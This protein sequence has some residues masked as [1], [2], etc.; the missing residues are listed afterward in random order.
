M[1]L[2]VPR[3]I[4]NWKLAKDIISATTGFGVNGVKEGHEVSRTDNL[5]LWKEAFAE[6]GLVPKELEPVDKNFTAVHYLDG[7]CTHLHRD[8]APE[9][10]V[11]VRCNV[12]LEKPT[13][14]GHLL[15]DD[16]VIAVQ[17]HDLWILLAS[18]ENHGTTKISGSKRVIYSFGALVE[19]DQIKKIIN[20]EE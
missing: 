8:E 19:L 11:H 2:L 7:V 15:I 17:K 16:E 18:M 13:K 20:K 10:L 5:H 3:V 12:L 4:P 9:G 14:G 6:F 1:K